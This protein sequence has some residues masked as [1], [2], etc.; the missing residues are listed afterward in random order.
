M[1]NRYLKLFVDIADCGSFSKAAEKMYISP[2]AIIKQINHYEEHLGFPLFKRSN[3]GL[4]L[5]EEGEI[6]YVEGKKIIRKTDRILREIRQKRSGERKVVRI[7][8][9][10]LFPSS[11]ILHLWAKVQRGCTDIELRNVPFSETGTHYFDKDDPVWNAVD[12][13]LVSFNTFQEEKGIKWLILEERPLCIGI[14]LRHPLA[15]RTLLH[16]DDFDGETIIIVDEGLSEYID[17]VRKEILE[18][19]PEC[20]IIDSPVYDVETFNR[21]VEENILMLSIQEWK[22]IHPSIITVPVEWDHVIPYGIMYR[23]NPPETVERFIKEI[24][25]ALT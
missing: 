11:S 18:H 2:N 9:S 15:D 13:L 6:L 20:R 19:C 14:P 5:T 8:S 23:E 12:L 21:C 4:K 17:Q 22:D 10:L 25:K 24:R 1:Y 3:H 16:L 7:G